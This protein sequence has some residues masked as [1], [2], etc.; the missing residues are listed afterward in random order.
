MKFVRNLKIGNRIQ[1]VKYGK[2]VSGTIESRL[3]GAVVITNDK[4]G[5][6]EVVDVDR[7]TKTI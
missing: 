7:I 2:N 3:P 5:K 6:L 1:A 4:T